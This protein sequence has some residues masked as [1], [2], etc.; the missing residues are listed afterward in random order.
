MLL[1]DLYCLLELPDQVVERLCRYEKERD[2]VLSQELQEKIMCRN[3]WGEGITELQSQLGEDT[4][5]IK[6]LYE[7]LRL[8]SVYSC[9]QY[10]AKGIPQQ[11]FIDSMKFCTRCL[12]E[13][14]RT[15]NAYKFDR[16]WWFPRQISLC[17]FRI[18]ALEF[19]FVDEEVK[20]IYIHIPSDADLSEESVSNSIKA[21][22]EFRK[23]YFPEWKNEKIVCA[24]WMLAPAM[25]ELLPEGSRLL[26]FKH[27]FET[28]QVDLEATWFMEWIYPGHE[29]AFETLPETTSLQRNMKAYLLA[30]NK[31][32]IAK[33][34]LKEV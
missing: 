1:S 9:A 20:E 7:L 18:G 15:Y 31:V 12:R 26:G 13:Y 17:E 25:E 4:D 29:G 23:V 2:F 3:S 27:R 28:V 30:G 5:G 14:F 32:G 10:E 11:V 33:G 19:E 6:V 34:Q 22:D 16:A 21:F 8:V 24:T